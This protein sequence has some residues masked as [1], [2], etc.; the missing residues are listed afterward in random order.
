M[1]KF[2]CSIVKKPGDI[3][4]TEMEITDCLVGEALIKV[5]FAAICGTDMHIYEDKYPAQLPKIIGHECSGEIAEINEPYGDNSGLK[6]GDKVVVQPFLSCGYCDACIT[7][8]T[9]VC[10]NQKFFGTKTDGCF[11]QYIKVPIDKLFKLP[12]NITPRTA[13]MAEPLAVGVH[14][15]R[16]SG[17][18]V[19]ETA[20]VMGAGP[21]GLIIAI[22]LKAAGA[23]NIVLT[24]VNPYR[25][26]FANKLGFTVINPLEENA[27]TELINANN[28]SRYHKI[29]EATAAASSYKLMFDMI[30]AR[31]VIMLIGLTS[32]QN[33]FNTSAAVFQEAT[34]RAIR[35]HSMDSFR[36]AVKLL[37]SGNVNA[38]VETLITNEFQFTKVKEAL[39]FAINDQEH[40]KVVLKF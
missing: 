38:A 32:T 39:E 21:I 3:I 1:E 11:S 7:G 30:K 31:G 17:F 24:E 36:F 27:S 8:H 25:L 18:M 20:L 33:P 14:A 4:I 5:D 34:I 10:V 23:T 2:L 6:K 26:N 13:C 35:I 19:G 16:E 15:V 12:T 40:M 22:V 9:N 28:G 37:G 29:F